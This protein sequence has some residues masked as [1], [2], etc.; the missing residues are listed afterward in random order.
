[1]SEYKQA[2]S[3]I[4]RVRVRELGFAHQERK[5]MEGKGRGPHTCWALVAG[6]R[7]VEGLAKGGVGRR[8]SPSYGRAR[9]TARARGVNGRR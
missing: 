5:G 1:M 6:E 2:N 4:T 9:E 7:T 8:R 3:Q